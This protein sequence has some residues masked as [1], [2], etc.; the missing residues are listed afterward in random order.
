M[1]IGFAKGQFATSVLAL[2]GYTTKFS[3]S[4]GHSS[5]IIFSV[6]PIEPSQIVSVGANYNDK[7]Q[8]GMGIDM[9]QNFQTKNLNFNLDPFIRI[10]F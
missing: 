5:Q 3:K 1:S 8:F 2:V 7:I 6:N 10:N 4:W 9:P